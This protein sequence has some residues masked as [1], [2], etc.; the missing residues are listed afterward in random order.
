MAAVSPKDRPGMVACGGPTPQTSWIA[1]C[2]GPRITSCMYTRRWTR[3]R[4]RI[5]AAA[6]AAAAVSTAT[7]TRHTAATSSSCLL[8]G[9]P[10][11][12]CLAMMCGGV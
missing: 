6:A 3:R 9:V 11:S 2:P 4:P 10:I 1:V 5:A 7:T 8:L 12:F